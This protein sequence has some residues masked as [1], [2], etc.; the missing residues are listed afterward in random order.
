M[1]QFNRKWTV[2]EAAFTGE[3]Y[4]SQNENNHLRDKLSNIERMFAQFMAQQEQ[5]NRQNSSTPVVDS[6]LLSGNNTQQGTSKGKGRGKRTTRTS[7]PVPPPRTLL[8]SLFA[9]D[10]DPTYEPDEDEDQ[11]V[12][13][14]RSVQSTHRAQVPPVAPVNDVGA[15]SVRYITSLQLEINR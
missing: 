3:S 13:S 1:L 15:S 7:P 11:S 2:N 14:G 8:G 4:S 9:R 5:L 10:Y 12:T 6:D